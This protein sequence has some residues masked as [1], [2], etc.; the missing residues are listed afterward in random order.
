MRL[1]TITLVKF[2]NKFK[3]FGDK[4]VNNIKQMSKIKLSRKLVEENLKT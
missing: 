1:L 4:A 3:K 2:L